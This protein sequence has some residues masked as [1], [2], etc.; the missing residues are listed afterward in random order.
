[1]QLV[2]TADAAAVCAAR[3]LVIDDEAN[4]ATFVGRAL[5]AK[6]LA[7]DVAIGGEAGLT[8]ALEGD[9]DLI[10]LDLRMG[11]VNGLVILRQ[12]MRAR[13]GQ[14]VLVLSAAADVAVK[15]RCLE[16]GATDF[17]AKPFDVAELV[18]RVGA[19]LRRRPDDA[20]PERHLRAGRL[21]LDLSLRT[22]D[23]G[24]GPIALSEREFAVL[25]H[26]M[27]R[28]GRPSTRRELLADV[29]DIDFDPGTNIVDVCVH[30]L[31]DKLGAGVIQTV[32]NRGYVLAP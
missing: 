17:L 27:T 23:A 10:V 15:V 13:P 28:P 6:G 16:S 30:R 31:R 20:R 32:R 7:V 14:R 2:A 18:A 12:V 1:M 3:V 25:R 29:W 5:R 26:L 11:G 24:A 19:Q 4:V 9:H 8:A 22:V 21:T